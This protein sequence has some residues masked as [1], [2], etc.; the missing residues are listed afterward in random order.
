MEWVKD[1]MLS[2]VCAALLAALAGALCPAGRGRKLTGLAGGLLLL[3]VM[4]K[5]LARLGAGS[6]ALAEF[7]NALTG[8]AQTAEAEELRKDIIAQQTA[9]YI[10]DKATALGI[11]DPQVQVRCR[12]TEDGFPA[13]ESVQ[14]RGSGDGEA[15]RA[16][17][18]AITADFGL[19]ASHQMLERT[20][21]P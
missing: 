8:Q 4:L 10:S 18:R 21:V 15:W 14:V 1:W 6:E 2:V 13:P 5:P 16:L 20:D 12:W 3:F 17:Q 19:D 11:V 9:A 7:Q